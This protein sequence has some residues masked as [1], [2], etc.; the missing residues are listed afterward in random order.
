[1][2]YPCLTQQ[3]DDPQVS[4]HLQHSLADSTALVYS[5]ALKDEE[6]GEATIITFTYLTI[7]TVGRDTLA[8][9]TLL[10]QLQVQLLTLLHLQPL[11]HPIHTL[12][13]HQ[14]HVLPLHTLPQ[15]QLQ[16]PYPATVLPTTY[17]YKTP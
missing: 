15:L 4:C 16:P 7:N 10:L 9:H 3:P 6:E 17:N 5:A 13:L 2:E 14:L 1:M 12:L 11:L 8:L